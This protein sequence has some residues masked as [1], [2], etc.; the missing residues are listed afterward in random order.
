M[1]PPATPFNEKLRLKN[2]QSFQILDTEE[3]TSFDELLEIAVQVSGCNSAM[4]SF[5]DK[6]R[7]WFKSKINF[8]A[9]EMPRKLSFCGHAILQDDVM[10]V[11]DAT[12]DSRFHD[13]PC[14]INN[15]NIYFYA[16]IPILS[17]S[18]FRL[19][20]VCV[21]DNK[22]RFLSA[23]QI[24]SLR[25]ISA[26]V[27]NL[28]ELR[29]KNLKLKKAIKSSMLEMEKN[30]KRHFLHNEQPQY[31]FDPYT[32]V[33]VD[34]NV[35]ALKLYGYNKAEFLK[36]KPAD[37]NL[38][39]SKNKQTNGLSKIKIVKDSQTIKSI[40]LTKA[41]KE[42]VTEVY[43]SSFISGGRELKIAT[44]KD[45]SNEKKLI[46]NLLKEK[47]IQMQKDKETVFLKKEKELTKYALQEN[48]KICTINL[49]LS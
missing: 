27:S 7:Q 8:E 38:I 40:H 10:I 16:G 9:D 20:S 11:N 34:V 48:I 31:M 24:E 4:I 12:K 25:N 43:I 14:V 32:L 6:D 13:N 26:Q 45:L 33:N 28:L 15:P 46:V 5:V 23:E 36:L 29:L 35:A 17:R 49:L 30:I 44:V 18:G 1:I 37:I 19:G 42:I 41:K 47:D 39:K 21:I 22:P 2:L 3:E